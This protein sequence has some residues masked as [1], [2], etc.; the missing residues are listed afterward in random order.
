MNR[1]A[2]ASQQVSFLTLPPCSWVVIDKLP[3]LSSP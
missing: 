3:Y 2:Q 1:W